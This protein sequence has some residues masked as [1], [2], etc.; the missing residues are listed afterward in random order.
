[1]TTQ[2][3]GSKEEI[4]HLGPSKGCPRRAAD[5]L[6]RCETHEHR[7][8][9]DACM[10]RCQELGGLGS[11][12]RLSVQAQLME[13]P[14]LHV[15]LY[16]Y[17][18][19]LVDHHDDLPGCGVGWGYWCCLCLCE[20]FMCL[21]V[22]CVAGHVYRHIYMLY[23]CVVCTSLLEIHLQPLYW[24]DLGH[25]ATAAS[26]LSSC[27]IQHDVFS[28]KSSAWTRLRLCNTALYPGENAEEKEKKES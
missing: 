7:P 16:R 2:I 1:M 28:P 18:F 23:M 25:G 3:N 6:S 20:H 11:M 17:M 21:S 8:T 14:T 9:L 15:W 4:P 26:H 19:S 10:S 24:L 5:P 12:G 27:Q 13:G 22:V